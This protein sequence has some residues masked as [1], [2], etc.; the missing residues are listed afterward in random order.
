MKAKVDKLD[1]NKLVNIL[2]GLYN[3]KAAG[4]LNV[5]KLKNVP[6]DLKQLSLI[7]CKQVDKNTRFNKLNTKRY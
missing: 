4:D 2:T 6:T 7:V 5:S 3:L 1:I